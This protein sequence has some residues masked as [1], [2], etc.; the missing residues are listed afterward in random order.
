MSKHF[1]PMPF[2]NLEARTDGGIAI[3][4]QMDEVMQKDSDNK[5]CLTEDTLSDGW[6]SEWLAKLR[7]DFL[8][9]EKPEACYSCWT[10]EDAGIDSK[11]QRALRDFPN[12]KAE[13]ERIYTELKKKLLMPTQIYVSCVRELLR[14]ASKPIKRMAHIT[15]SGFHNIR[16]ISKKFNYQIT[17][18]DDFHRPEHMNQF[19]EH[20]DLSPAE[21]YETF[22]MG[23]GLVIATDSPQCVLNGIREHGLQAWN[24]G[25]IEQGEGLVQISAQDLNEPIILKNI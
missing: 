19:L 25:H 21:A 15:G 2:V 13:A 18:P 23:I 22:N 12:A 24:I 6:K 7:Q 17:L 4:C 5:F 10:A 20:L 16:R 11:R 1:C 9:G 3:C 14:M 8:D